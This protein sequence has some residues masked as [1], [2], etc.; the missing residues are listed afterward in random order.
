MFCDDRD[1]EGNVAGYPTSYFLS[2]IPY[3]EHVF[4]D[5]YYLLE[6]VKERTVSS[7]LLN[8]ISIL[9][10]PID[11]EKVGQNNSFEIFKEKNKVKKI[12]WAGRF[13]EQK[14]PDILKKI[15]QA[16]PDIEF[17]V[18]GK[19]VLSKREYG[20]DT[21]TNV[22]LMGLYK[23]IFEIIESGCDMFLYTSEWDG[24][25]TM[26]LRMLELGCPILASNV[27]GVSEVIPP[28][29]LVNDLE[30]IEEY[31]NKIHYFSDNYQEIVTVF[32]DKIES[33]SHTRDEANFTNTLLGGK[34]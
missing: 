3:I 2:C 21:I 13:D 16:C 31:V 25:P 29:G 6:R 24:V 20:L 26:L 5:S 9:S 11:K 15:A 30:D 33:L 18:W 19:P 27:G 10:T 8:K 23:D 4:F 28:I 22:T 12:G 1:G 7:S 32:Q 34:Q 14:R 17:Y